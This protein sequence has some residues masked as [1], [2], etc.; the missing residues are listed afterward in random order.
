MAADE[1]H[2]DRKDHKAYLDTFYPFV[3][4]DA[5]LPGRAVP[6]AGSPGIH[7]WE[8]QRGWR[9]RHGLAVVRWDVGKPSHIDGA[10]HPD[11]TRG[12][13]GR[14]LDYGWRR[15]SSEKRRWLYGTID[16]RPDEVF[17]KDGAQQPHYMPPKPGTDLDLERDLANDTA[18]LSDL[19]DDTFAHALYVVLRNHEFV[20]TAN[21]AIWS[22]GDRRAARLVAG[23]RGLGESYHDYFLRYDFPGTWPDDKPQQL[24]LL[25]RQMELQEGGTM[26]AHQLDV[27]IG[28]K[29]S[30]K[31]IETAEQA[32][33][34]KRERRQ[35]EEEARSQLEARLA[36]MREK[37]AELENERT[38]DVMVSLRAH[39]MRLGWRTLNEADERRLGEEAMRQGLSLLDDIKRFEARPAADP[40]VWWMQQ[41][42]GSGEM[43]MMAV[44]ALAA[45]TK[46]EQTV[47]FGL[48][49]RVDAL[50][51]RG[52]ATQTE[53]EA[54]LQRALAVDHRIGGYDNR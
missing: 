29:V 27:R 53:H 23:L 34:T 9:T 20:R 6:F 35:R 41:K 47:L 11:G 1:D 36:G 45:L 42:R 5:E 46:D 22:C 13:I 25:R 50:A 18:F 31:L 54:L 14:T 7:V 43:R 26:F 51:E 52:R 44:R 16:I 12:E 8:G 40:G 28:S 2:P 3:E 32:E 30:G 49:G 17:F 37:I 10:L 15:R 21:L 24:A 38:P 33:Q 39:L 48:R 19:K 4:Q